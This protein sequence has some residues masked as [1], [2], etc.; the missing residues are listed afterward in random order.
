MLCTL[1][2][3]VIS[4][5]RPSRIRE[6]ANFSLNPGSKPSTL[7]SPQGATLYLD[8]HRRGVLLDFVKLFLFVGPVP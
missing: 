5:H 1:P 6:V 7:F 4:D 8:F 2:G 3:T